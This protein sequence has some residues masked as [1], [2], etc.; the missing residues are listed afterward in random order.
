MDTEK[1]NEII[2]TNGIFELEDIQILVDE[3]EYYNDMI[4]ELEEDNSSE[5]LNDYSE[6]IRKNQELFLEKRKLEDELEEINNMQQRLGGR[7]SKKKADRKFALETEIQNIESQMQNLKANSKEAKKEINDIK[8]ELPNRQE[9]IKKYQ[10]SIETNRQNLQ[11]IYDYCANEMIIIEDAVNDLGEEVKNQANR[12]SNIKNENYASI[13]EFNLDMKDALDKLSKLQKDLDDAINY[14]NN[15]YFSN[16]K[17]VDL[18]SKSNVINNTMSK[19]KPEVLQNPFEGEKLP[20]IDDELEQIVN[21]IIEISNSQENTINYEQ[22]SDI[23][24]EYDYIANIDIIKEKLKNE[25]IN[26]VDKMVNDDEIVYSSIKNLLYWMVNENKLKKELADYILNDSSNVNYLFEELSAVLRFCNDDSYENVDLNDNINNL[27]DIAVKKGLCKKEEITNLKEENVLNS[28][29]EIVTHSFIVKNFCDEKMSNIINKLEEIANKQ[30]N[31]VTYDQ[32]DEINKEFDSFFLQDELVEKLNEIGIISVE[33]LGK[34]SSNNNQKEQIIYNITKIGK[35]QNGIILDEQIDEEIDVLD[36]K[37]MFKVALLSLLK[38][39]DIQVLKAKEY[40]KQVNIS[41]EQNEVL[42]NLLT[43]ST[44]QNG[45]LTFK[46]LE[47]LCRDFINDDDFGLI[48][49]AFVKVKNIDL[50]KKLYLNQASDNNNANS[51]DDEHEKMVDNIIKRIISIGKK[52]GYVTHEQINELANKL[53]QEDV[54]RIIRS[55]DVNNIQHGYASDFE[56]KDIEFFGQKFDNEKDAINYYHSVEDLINNWNKSV[57]KNDESEYYDL[58]AIIEKSGSIDDVESLTKRILKISKLSTEKSSIILKNVINKF[59]RKNEKSKNESE[60]SEKKSSKIKGKI[61][62]SFKLTKEKG[63]VIFDKIRLKMNKKTEK[64]LTEKVD[65][66]V[67]EAI[68]N[69]AFITRKRVN[70]VLSEVSQEDINTILN[71]LYKLYGIEVL[72]NEYENES[73]PPKTRR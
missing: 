16:R 1:I 29:E 37:V 25:N 30:D 14:R 64:S 24:K 48:V 12:I 46:Q 72:E 32:I 44:N 6:N 35:N 59:Q 57:K 52:Q 31:K 54:N 8:E 9:T 26:V 60:E 63:K 34:D 20:E 40:L 28:F 49:Y 38:S 21:K 42:E 19:D 27:I 18:I 69:D 73:E 66:L 7:I 11:K 4:E 61:E 68:D 47:D 67:D 2:A 33:N 58:D 70:E 36:D 62:N 39:N 41:D 17:I 56:K 13:D 53:T 15:H 45:K 3:I 71:N 55:L 51:S 43:T 50:V 10:D 5:L 23:E 22:I 65:E